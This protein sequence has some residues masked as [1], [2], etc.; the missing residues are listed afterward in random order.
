MTGKIKTL[1]MVIWL[2]LLTFGGCENLAK[3]DLISNNLPLKASPTQVEVD[4]ILIPAGKFSMGDAKNEKDP[5]IRMSQPVRQVTIN[6]FYM[7]IHEVTVGQFKQFIDDC[8]Y[9]PDLVRVNGWNFER[10]WHCVTRYSPEDNHPM[11]FVSWSDANN[12]AK[13]L[14]KR[15]PTE[16]EWEY[17]ARGGLVGNRYTWGDLIDQGQASC[18]GKSW[19]DQWHRTSPV[20]SFPANGFGLYD[21]GGNVWEWCSDWFHDTN[22]QRRSA[23]MPSNQSSNH[24]KRRVLRGGSWNDTQDS[25]LRV[26]IRLSGNPFIHQNFFTLGSIGFRCASDVE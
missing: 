21:M 22:S 2:L 1:N 16:S 5:W 20:G 7:D 25:G 24:Q 4:Q 15:L 12:Y 11:V 17:A 14:G 9:R 23:N 10:F 13:W 26:A 18:R 6:S 19:R 3:D 8:H